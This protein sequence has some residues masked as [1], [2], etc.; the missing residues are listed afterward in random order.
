MEGYNNIDKRIHQLSQIIAKANRTFVPKK[1]DDSH[2]N[3][4]FNPVSR[5]VYGRWI[6]SSK[7]K[8]ILTLNLKLFLFEWLD[9]NFNIIQSHIIEGKTFSQIE[10]NIANQIVNVGLKKKGFKAPLHFDIPEYD[11]INEPFKKFD[12]KQLKGWERYRSLANN[13]SLELLTIFQKAVDVRIW[14][15]HFDTGIYVEATEK[16][17][18]GF[19]L[20]MKDSVAGSPYFYF[21]GYGINGNTIDYTN[22]PSLTIGKFIVGKNW[23]G[24]IVTLPEIKEVNSA[25]LQVFLKEVSQWFLNS[26]Q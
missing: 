17:G 10:Q 13:L 2:T 4:Y 19:G 9:N 21:S 6:E 15:H 7:G 12:P 18:V 8:V 16:L 3:L 24:V 22:V 5:Q 26:S 11:F 20:A 14:P 1:R 25:T 23:N